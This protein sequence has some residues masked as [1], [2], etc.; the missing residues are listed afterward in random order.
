MFGEDGDVEVEM[1]LDRV[2][3]R[4]QQAETFKAFGVEQIRVSSGDM[5]LCPA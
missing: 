3:R 1:L 4:V 5:M 2:L